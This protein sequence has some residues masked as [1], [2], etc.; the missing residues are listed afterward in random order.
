[1]SL[2]IRTKLFL[3]LLAASTIAV[4]GMQAFIRWSFENGLVELAEAHRQERIDRIAER[5]VERYREDGGWE[6]LAQDKRLWIGTLFG[7]DG[8]ARGESMGTPS[9]GPPSRHMGRWQHRAM[10]EPGV[11]PPTRML[12]HARESGG[13][14]LRLEMRLMLL[15][16][17]GHPVYGHAD[18]VR[19]TVRFPLRLDGRPIGELAL[20]PGP[21]VPESGEL[22]FKERQTTALVAIALAMIALSAAFAIPLSK[23]LSRP[24]LGFRDTARRLAAGDYSARAPTTGDDELGNLG[25]DINALAETLERNEHARRRW[26]ADISHELRTPLALLRAQIEALQDGVRPLDR[27]SVDVL[28]ADALRLTRLVDDLYELSMTDLGALSYRKTDTE[29]AEVLEA[30]LDTF[31]TRFAAAGLAL[32]LDDQL[33]GPLVLQADAHRLSQLFRNLLRNSL[34]YSDAGGG[35][36]VRLAREA[37]ALAIDFEDTAPDVPPQSLPHLFER[38]YRAEGSR[39][40]NTGGAGLGLAICRNIVEAHGGT[41]EA[42]PS[43]LGGL[44]IRIRLPIQA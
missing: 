36:R 29:P 19:D 14:P 31:R 13:P 32:T 28:H 40:R 16:S 26:V 18:Q 24:V 8:G 21:F 39:N 22:R 37:D 38:L 2:S 12:M 17:N 33:T 10:G 41:I 15:D 3:T 1:M 34:Q 35:L 7:R 43:A 42:R 30:D 6:R 25:R 4:L 23:R 20:L 11:W 27:A 5:L 9:A 44:W